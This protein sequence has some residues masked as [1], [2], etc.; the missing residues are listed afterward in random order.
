MKRFFSVLLILICIIQVGVSCS[1]DPSFFC[2]TVHSTN[3]DIVISGVITDVDD[4]GINVDILTLIRGDESSSNI[5]IWDGT[6][7]DCNGNVSLAAADFGA[8]GDSLILCLPQIIDQ[9]NDWDVI[10]DYRRPGT[11][12]NT[13]YLKVTDN[14]VTGRISGY[15]GS[16]S[17][18]IYNWNY[19]TFL[20][21]YLAESG[22]SAI[23][24]TE[25]QLTHLD[26]SLYPNPVTDHLN[27]DISTDRQ[28]LH[29]SLY[30]IDGR[31]LLST[32]MD[33]GSQ[34]LDLSG[35]SPGLYL[36]EVRV[37]DQVIKRD[38]VVKV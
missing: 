37:A 10:G 3:F 28:G 26:V 23:V 30:S 38:R 9:E 20:A 18:N 6:D 5:R 12:S 24:S 15:Y 34:Q 17:G 29:L 31:E 7:W 1:F 11:T 27:V 21:S 33:D 2:N 19:D 4:D 14:V 13:P 25:E 16:S 32:P 36:L 8:V 35:Y 22:C